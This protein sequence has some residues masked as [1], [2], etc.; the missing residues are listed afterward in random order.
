MGTKYRGKAEEVFPVQLA[1]IIKG[2]S[3]LS[4]VEQGQFGVLC[5][6]LGLQEAN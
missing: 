6:R 3:V 4:D 1:G 5:R 2:M